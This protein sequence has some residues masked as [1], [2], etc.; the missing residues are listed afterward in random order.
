M[1][2]S[3]GLYLE[4]M[5]RRRRRRRHPRRARRATR[6]SAL[7]APSSLR[8]GPAGA[9]RRYEF[10]DDRA[11]CR[12]LVGGTSSRTRGAADRREYG[13]NAAPAE[14]ASGVSARARG[15]QRRAPP[16]Q[17]RPRR[18][19]ARA[20]GGAAVLR[21]QP[22]LLEPRPAAGAKPTRDRSRLRRTRALARARDVVRM[23][24]GRDRSRLAAPS[25]PRSWAPGASAGRAPRAALEVARRH[26]PPPRQL[27][28]GGLGER[29]RAVRRTM[30]RRASET[31][32]ARA[33]ATTAAWPPRARR[34][35]GGDAPRQGPVAASTCGA[36]VRARHAVR[37]RARRRVRD[38]QDVL[39]DADGC[40]LGEL[41]AR[42]DLARLGCA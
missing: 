14:R 17:R 32:R 2:T 37:A 5:A 15:A 10:V 40:N 23:C 1:P 24:F 6:D 42:E 20:R 30:G 25:R 26:H 39:L 33:S 4:P 8:G 19:G 11:A 34:R 3:H 13:E 21:R 38:H 29:P 35:A 31:C 28:A 22:V 41:G 27:V 12:A 9:A 18:R 16:W 36:K 7:P